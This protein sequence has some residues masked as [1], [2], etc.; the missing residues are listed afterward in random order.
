MA[1]A[2][3]GESRF[4]NRAQRLCHG[5]R[6]HAK[7]TCGCEKKFFTEEELDHHHKDQEKNAAGKRH[8]CDKCCRSFKE[9]KHLNDHKLDKDHWS[10]GEKARVRADTGR[11]YCDCGKS[12]KTPQGLHSHKM[13]KPSLAKHH[14]C[15]RCADT[16]KTSDRLAQHQKDTGH[17][18]THIKTTKDARQLYMISFHNKYAAVTKDDRK[19]SVATVKGVLDQ[20][21]KNVR[22]QKGG[23]VFSSDLVKAG[24]HAVKTKIGKADEFDWNVPLNT[25]DA[26]VRDRGPLLYKFDNPVIAFRY[27]I[28]ARI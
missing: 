15:Y 17:L 10:P 16:F 14:P 3:C 6:N 24:S 11:S 13:D 5:Y 26:Q 22:D 9:K 7:F 19:A 23:K 20:I 25:R 4:T 18:S 2:Q 27:Q 1:C 8:A 12:F 21:M 28:I